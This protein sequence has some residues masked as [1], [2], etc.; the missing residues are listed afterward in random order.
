MFAS[1]L[2]EETGHPTVPGTQRSLQKAETLAVGPFP[3]LAGAA[4]EV[5]KAGFHGY[6]SSWLC[7]FSTVASLAGAVPLSFPW[8]TPT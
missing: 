2:I 8:Q 5:F 7:C 1:E 4:W 3:E 6:P